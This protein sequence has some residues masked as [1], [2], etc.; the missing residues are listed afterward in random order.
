MPLPPALAARLAKRGLIDKS[1]HKQPEEE[2]FAEDYDDEVT[3]KTSRSR[4]TR[5]IFHAKENPLCPN[6][7][8]IYH[9]CS[10]FCW[11]RWTEPRGPFPLDEERRKRMLLRYP[12]PSG[13]KEVFDG[14]TGRFY[15]WFMETDE[16]SWLPPSH[17]RAKVGPPAAVLSGERR[18]RRAEEEDSESEEETEETRRHIQDDEVNIPDIPLPGVKIKGRRENMGP[19]PPKRGRGRP[20]SD[21]LDPMDPAAYSDI[22]RGKWSAGLRGDGENPKTGVDSTVS[23]PL[24]QMRPYPSP[25]AIL[26]AQ[27]KKKK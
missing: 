9:D 13:W 10:M 6:K 20:E 21:E 3:E 7:S 19:P 11:K 24:Y 12:V 17:P 14:G 1:A 18:D 8:N 26:K 4:E 27:G 16:V 22:P 25:G 23:G 2:V 5:D 15:Y